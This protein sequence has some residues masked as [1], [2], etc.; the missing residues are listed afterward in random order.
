MYTSINIVLF[1]SRVVLNLWLTH[2]N[3]RI[4]IRLQF[5]FCGVRIGIKIYLGSTFSHKENLWGNF[6][7]LWCTRLCTG[8]LNSIWKPKFK[9]ETLRQILRSNF[10]LIMM[11]Q[12]MHSENY[13]LWKHIFKEANLAEVSISSITS[14]YPG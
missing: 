10:Y 9:E 13:S 4:I 11:Q 3:N 14:I 7:Q 1:N 2:P 8:K 5:Q 6:Y 12:I